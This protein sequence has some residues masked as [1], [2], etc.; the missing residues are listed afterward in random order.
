VRGP[1]MKISIVTPSYN[2]GAFVA[3][4]LASVA[5]QQGVDYE[6]VVVD[7]GSTDETVEILRHFDRPLVWTSE[8]DGGQADAVNRG[9]V[10]TNGEI[11]GWLNSDDVYYPDALA[12]VAAYFD[13]H[14]EVDVVYGRADHID[15]T[16][17]SFEEYPT[18]PWDFSRLK[19]RCFVCQPALFLRRRVIERHGPLNE[20]L[21]YCM[22]YEYWLR[23]GRDGAR[24]A[25][26][27][28]KLAGSRL[29]AENKTL[30]ERVAVHREINDMFHR[31]FGTVPDRWLVNYA[32]AV[33]EQRVSRARHRRL[34]AF[35]L[36]FEA[37]AGA[38]RWNRRITRSMLAAMWN[39]RNRVT[40]AVAE[41]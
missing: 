18:E 4:T 40:T 12:R 10:S 20:G 41:S 13:A 29:Y 1:A 30:G 28:A 14:P 7:G 39:G 5:V 24:F 9:F 36:A 33:V 6:H 8:K 32:Y 19:E 26:L 25:F 17:R 35:E 31:L 2:Q 3:A 16:G 23:L 27:D 21:R 37:V 22:D 11:V 34:F 38:L 15:R